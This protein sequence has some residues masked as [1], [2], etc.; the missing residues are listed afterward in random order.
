MRPLEV[1][2]ELWLE[3]RA[4]VS[5]GRQ[6]LEKLVAA[7]EKNVSQH[8]RISRVIIAENKW[9]ENWNS[10]AL[11]VDRDSND[12]IEIY[13]TADPGGPEAE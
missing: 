10:P 5:R 1:G 11:I 7:Q 12:G 13:R 8:R 4:I 3:H 9:R 6:T 2:S